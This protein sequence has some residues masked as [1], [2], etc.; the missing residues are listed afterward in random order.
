VAADGAALTP[1]LAALSSLKLTGVLVHSSQASPPPI[2]VNNNQTTR[3]LVLRPNQRV[4]GHG[5]R[6]G[7]V[8]RLAD[9]QLIYVAPS[10]SATTA[11]GGRPAATP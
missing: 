1:L 4:A 5:T 6:V 3:P 7:A 11:P 10:A 9:G 8:Y 2:V